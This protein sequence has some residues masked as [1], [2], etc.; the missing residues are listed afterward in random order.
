MDPN[1]VYRAM[2]NSMRAAEMGVWVEAN[3]DRARRL[4]KVLRH[5]LNNH[6]NWDLCFHKSEVEDRLNSVFKETQ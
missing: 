3:H 6:V 5:W 4:A 1:K 2:C